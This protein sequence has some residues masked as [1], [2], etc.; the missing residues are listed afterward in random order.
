[1]TALPPGLITVGVSLVTPPPPPDSLHR[2]TYWSRHSV[3]VRAE[4]P[5]DEDDMRSP[6]A[7]TTK[8][9]NSDAHVLTEIHPF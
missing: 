3:E 6:D 7:N 2:L 9:E 8:R 5:G 4:L 1:M